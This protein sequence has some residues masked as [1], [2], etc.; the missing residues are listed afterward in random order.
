MLNLLEGFPLA[1]LGAMSADTVH[2]VAEAKKIAFA[3]RL[4]HCGDPRFTDIPVDRLISKEHAAKRRAEIDMRRATPIGLSLESARGDTSYFCVADGQGNAISFI[5]SLSAGWGCGVVAGETG[6]LLN[7]RAGRGFRL[8]DGH[9][10]RLAGGRRT[11]HTLNCYILADAGRPVLVGGTPGGDQQ[12]QWNVQTITNI[13]DHGLDPQTAIEAP[14]WYS[15]PGTDPANQGK[16][17]ELRL[18]GRLPDDTLEELRGLGH[19]VQ[20]LEPWSAGGAV[21]LIALDQEREVLLGA[22]DPRAE[23]MALGV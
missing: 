17:S 22:T 18:E 4:A 10:N 12:P 6:I 7:N 13:I 2:I 3:D 20:V 1:E 11:M 14:R 8:V 9:P 5:H 16:P 23:G 19:S 21:Q 15:F